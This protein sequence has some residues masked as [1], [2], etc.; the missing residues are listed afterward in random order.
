[1]SPYISDIYHLQNKTR[2]LYNAAYRHIHILTF[3]LLWR[4]L[5]S[6]SHFIQSKNTQAGINSRGLPT[7]RG[8]L[9]QLTQLIEH[10]GT[11]LET[12]AISLVLE[13]FNVHARIS[14]KQYD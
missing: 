12:L 9:P 1:M 13:D 7:H 11:F 2:F 14:T 5:Q 10:G 3:L 8:D 6:K 4:C